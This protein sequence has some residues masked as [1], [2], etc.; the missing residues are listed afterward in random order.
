MT[1]AQQPFPD[2]DPFDLEHYLFDGYRLHQP[3]NC[4]D[5]LYSV[6]THCWAAIPS[7]RSSVNSL[8]TQLHNLQKQLQAFV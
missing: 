3:T 6:L 5:Q 7:E 4:P 1:K 8:Y 2:V